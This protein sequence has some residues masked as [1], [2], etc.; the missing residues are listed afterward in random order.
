MDAALRQAVR[1]RARLCCEYCQLPEA[2]APV[3]PFQVE[4]IIAKQHGG[5]D[6]FGNLALAC[7]RCN[8]CKGPNL[9]GRD[10]KTRKIVRLF[11]P[12]RMKWV[13][14]FRWEGPHLIGR[15]PVGRATIAVLEIND[16]DRVALREALIE[17]GI[18]P[19][20]L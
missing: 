20:G 16:E 18:F 14:H 2:Q 7:H 3:T 9:S 10:P 1:R 8:L 17:E 12:R 13:K 5:N 4:H 11:H 15:S 19:P 6:S